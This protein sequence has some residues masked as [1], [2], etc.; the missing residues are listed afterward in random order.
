M[1]YFKPRMVYLG[2]EWPIISSYLAVQAWPFS[3]NEGTKRPASE[4]QLFGDFVIVGRT[5][6]V[7]GF[8]KELAGDTY[9]LN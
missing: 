3:Q 2:V 4:M 7:R 9:K 8:N 1:G 5:R 6:G